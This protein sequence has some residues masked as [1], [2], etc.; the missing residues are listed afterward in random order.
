VADILDPVD[1][2][3]AVLSHSEDRIARVFSAAILSLRDQ[4]N[5]EELATM[6]EEGRFEEAISLV[7]HAAETVGQASTAVF[8]TSGQSAAAFLS[9]ADVGRI[10]FDQVNVRAVAQMR[11]NQLELVT[12]FTDEQR[13][14]L[15]TSLEQGVARGL[16]PIQQA[17]DFRDVVG[18][19]DFQ[20]AAVRNYRR[21]LEQ[22]GDTS[23][24]PA[25]QAESL[26][27]RLRD[28]RSD[29]SVM[30][31]IQEGKPLTPKQIDAMVQRY[32]EGYIK[33]R[34]NVIGRTEALKV[35]HQGDRETYNQAL[36]R[37]LF[38]RD[39]LRKDWNTAMDGRE[40]PSHHDL[41][42]TS[43]SWDEEFQGRD[44]RLLY[45][46]DPTAPAS[47]IIQCRCLLTTRIRPAKG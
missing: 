28:G 45:P 17:R 22:A 12:Q 34:A 11:Q 44:G 13:Q 21:L 6:L 43:L 14:V 26:S 30:R 4:L 23:L 16:N 8:I 3:D 9:A 2:I 18:L 38:S 46:G 24:P 37:G 1:R 39:Q 27:R 25:D 19:T 32:S 41:N 31:A 36:E 20:S 7:Q 33:Y 42:G 15:R 35:V 5:L 10:V 40:R 47:E 29:R